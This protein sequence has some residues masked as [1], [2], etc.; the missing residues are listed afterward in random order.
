MDPAHRAAFEQARALLCAVGPE[1]ERALM[2]ASEAH[3]GQYDRS[4]KPYIFHPLHL[5]LHASTPEERCAALLHDVLEDTSVSAA[6]LEGAGFDP[7]VLRA[8]VALTRTPDES[9]EAFI[10]RVARDRLASRVKLL[11]LAHNSDLSRLP[12]PPSEQDLE[13]TR[14]Y[15]RARLRLEA[16][17]EKRNL[18]VVLE[19]AARKLARGAATLPIVRGDHVTLAYRV[20][21]TPSLE[22]YLDGERAIGQEITLR[23]VAE[24][25]SDGV[26]AWLLELDGSSRRKLDGAALHLTVSRSNAAR[27][28]DAGE[29][30]ATGARAPLN[31]LLRG[32]LEW[33]DD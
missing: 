3:R 15:E 1:V 7:A 24:C 26:Q 20:T 5:A 8:V 14:K 32:T 9:Y 2:I 16:E 31:E 19:P 10:E 23:A 28:R 30:L 6:E 22:A 12:D 4:G 17:L 13:R 25:R 27:S 18:Y 21:P 33:V 29:L 11:D